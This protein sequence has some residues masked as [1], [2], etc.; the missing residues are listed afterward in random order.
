MPK[1]FES[2]TIVKVSDLLKIIDQL[3]IDQMEYAELTI[4]YDDE[5][6]ILDGSI[7]IAGIPNYESEN[8][9]KHYDFISAVDLPNYCL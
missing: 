7:H 5:S 3:Y 1:Q 2:T 6:D 8:S 4:R 9:T